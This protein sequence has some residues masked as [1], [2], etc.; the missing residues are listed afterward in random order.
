MTRGPE[1]GRAPDEILREAHTLAQQGCLEITLLGQ[2]VNS[3]QYTAQGQTTDL[4]DL[5]NSLHDMPGIQRLKFV[6]NF[7]KDMTPRLLRT[8]RDLPKCSPYLHVP[9]QSGSN[10][11]LRRMKR[12][13]TVEEYRDMMHC[14]WDT[15]PNAAVSSDFIVGFPGETTDGFCGDGGCRAASF[16]SRTALSSSTARGRERR[17]TSSCRTT[18]RTT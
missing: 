13:Y 1:Q 10:A 3:Y 12:G 18:S 14:I 15:V 4:A 17:P 2:T 8:V 11:V 16:G 7:P 5:L 9:L 6:T